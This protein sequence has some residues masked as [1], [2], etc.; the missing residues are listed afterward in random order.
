MSAVNA[1]LLGECAPGCILS[2]SSEQRRILLVDLYL[3]LRQQVP[4]L[5]VRDVR[6]TKLQI[7]GKVAMAAAALQATTVLTMKEQLRLMDEAHFD[8]EAAKEIAAARAKLLRPAPLADANSVALA[9]HERFRA[10]HRD[11]V[12]LAAIF[13]GQH[14]GYREAARARLSREADK[15]MGLSADPDLKIPAGANGSGGGGGD[16][17]GGGLE[18]VPLEVASGDDDD[19]DGGN[20]AGSGGSGSPA[21]AAPPIQPVPPTDCQDDD[22][23]AAG[24]LDFL[25]RPK[26]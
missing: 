24:L 1:A 22:D 20:G 9:L 14:F 25:D 13:L 2:L 17:G 4:R 15:R 5:V 19:D 16:G 6:K 11:A 10:S 12:T 23:P 21:A 18:L 8:Y 3:A 7:A 26:G